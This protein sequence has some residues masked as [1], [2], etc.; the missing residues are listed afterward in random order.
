[1]VVHVNR[2][3]DIL[4]VVDNSGSM[5]EEQGTLAT[6]LASFIDVLEADNVE[7]NYRIGIT[8]TDNGNPWCGGTSPEGGALRL[9]SCKG[10]IEEFIF[11]GTDPPT[12][13]QDEACN[14]VC[15]HD[16]IEIRPTTTDVDQTPKPHP[17][18]ENIEGTTNLPDG[19]TT[20]EALQCVLP[21]GINGCGFES[22]LESMYKGLRRA[23]DSGE[24]SYGFLRED[25]ILSVVIVTDEVDCSYRVDH[26]SIFLQDGDRVFWSDPAAAYPTSAV[27][28]NAGVSC[29]GGPGT[30]DGCEP[31]DYAENGDPASA[32][33]AVLHPLSRY[34]D[35]LQGFELDKQTRNPGQQVLVAII[36]G[37][38][39]SYQQG[40]EI[41]YQDA[42]DPYFQDAYGI[43]PG[44]SSV[45]GEAVPPVRLREFAEAF[46]V[47]GDRNLY[48]VCESDYTPAISA[49]AEVIADQLRPACVTKCVAD[50]D[51]DPSNGLT[52]MCELE[53]QF[54]T[55]DG[56][57][58]TSVP[59]C[60][61]DID[62]G[63]WDFPSDDEHVCF[64]ELTHNNTPSGIDDISPDCSEAG[65]NLEF[66]VERRTGHTA[67]RGTVL[68]VRCEWSD[69]PDVDCPDL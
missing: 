8:T 35:L 33:D 62:A 5:G 43:G 49:I 31:Q 66:R 13:K 40:G 38:P 57:E 61:V 10:R 15:V 63:T 53:Q 6:S 44:C 39:D 67:P 69:R 7:A 37:V 46:A 29:T 9:S 45:A 36:A 65:F 56:H 32:A 2:D 28:W 4:F 21:Q 64:I 20:A 25:A 3:V 52:P 50:S 48:S 54:P 18:L 30:Y 12:N 1:L 60:T 55:P 24:M 68:R 41:V 59:R 11:D 26:A 51:R 34:V 23:E 42:R 22:H 14:D 16:S 58:T 17:W 47:G 27:C 19:V